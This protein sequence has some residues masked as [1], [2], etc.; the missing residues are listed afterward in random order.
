M[1]GDFVFHEG[2][3]VAVWLVGAFWDWVVVGGNELMEKGLPK[4]FSVIAGSGGTR[5]C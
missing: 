4:N 2:V 5:R 3:A 1:S